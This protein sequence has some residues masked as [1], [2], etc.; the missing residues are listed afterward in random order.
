VDTFKKNKQG[1]FMTKLTFKG[2]PINTTGNLPPLHT[3][4]PSFRLVDKDLKEHTLQEFHGR[5]KLLAT[6]PSLDTGV[7]SLMAKH[8][9]LFGKKHPN[10]LILIISADLP[11]AQKRFCEQEDV[12][13]VLTLS[14]MRDKEFGKDYGILIQDG[15]LAG[16][17][18]RSVFVIDEKDHVLYQ[19]LVP[20][21]THEPDYHKALEFLM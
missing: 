20:E 19:E 18:A 8:F 5:K 14:M 4:A 3:K 2:N 7:C 1:I 9:N 15:P 12:H 11:F 16:I 6:V 21:I 13:N 10:A 17:L